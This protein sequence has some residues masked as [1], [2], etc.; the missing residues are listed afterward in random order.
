MPV[1]A[2]VYAI[3]TRGLTK[4]YPGPDGTTTHAVQGLDLAVEEGETFAF[5]GPNGAGKSTTIAMLCALAR[6]TAGHAT[7]VAPTCAPR[8]TRYGDG[9]ACCSS[10]ALW[11]PT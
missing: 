2:L 3:R 7:V 5:L 6:P 8:P 1:P 9:S 4:S 10:T 11:N